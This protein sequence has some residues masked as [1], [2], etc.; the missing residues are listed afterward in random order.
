MG[1]PPFMV[2]PAGGAAPHPPAGVSVTEVDD[3]AALAV[4]DRVLAAG[5]PVPSSPA[6]LP[7]LGGPTRFWLAWRD[8]EPV[9]TALSH[10]A[11]GVV[12]VEAV[13][14]LPDHRGCGIG[15][16]VTWAATVAEPALPAVLVASD[17]GVGVYRRMG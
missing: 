15:A 4:W 11:H 5:F 14:T 9:A 7:L 6:P 17:D 3:P 16:A 10:T 8:G 13:A 12:T 2:R 1:Y